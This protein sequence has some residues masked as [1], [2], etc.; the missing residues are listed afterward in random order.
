MSGPWSRL[1]PQSWVLVCECLCQAALVGKLKVLR[2]PS[3]CDSSPPSARTEANKLQGAAG[4]QIEPWD[5]HV[6]GLVEQVFHAALLPC[7]WRRAGALVA[8]KV[9]NGFIE[10]TAKCNHWLFKCRG[11]RGKDK[12]PHSDVQALRYHLFKMRGGTS[13]ASACDGS[14]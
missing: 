11:L 6:A 10:M 1:S 4:E 12:N 13:R 7:R 5:Q 9:G 3:P 14:C 8:A 2:H